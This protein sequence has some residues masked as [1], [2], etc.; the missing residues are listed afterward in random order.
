MLPFQAETL[1][2]P[3]PPKVRGVS[4][5]R[6]EAYFPSPADW[7]DEVLYF[8]LPD[9]FSDGNEAGRPR[10]DHSAVPA[11]RPPGWRWDEWARSGAERYQ[12]GTLAGVTSK[13]DYIRDLG[14]TTIWL[15]P[16]FKQRGH[17]DTFH[18]YAIQ[19]FLDVDP[20]FGTRR[21]L[22]DLVAAAHGKKL[23]VILD[24]I[25][26]HTGCNWLY[27]NGEREPRFRPFPEFYEKGQFFDASGNPTA[28]VASDD[29]GVW[30]E[31]L[32]ADDY[33]T[34]A[35]TGSL[36]AGDLF[37]DHAEFRRTDFLDLRD[38]NFDGTAALDD[39]AR[40]YKYWVA[41][42][43]CDGFRIDTLKHVGREAG[44]N[45]CGSIKEFASNL[46]KKD[47]F[48]V[49]EVAGSDHDARRFAEAIGS[50]LNATLDIGES[51]AAL[52]AVAQGL[53]PP[54]AYFDVASAWDPQ[55]GSHRN[56]GER[57]V[58]IL[59]D[60]DHVSGVKLRFSLDAPTDHQVAAGVAI[61][62]FALGIPCIYY[63]TEQALPGGPEASERAFLTGEP[64]DFGKSDR[65][66]REAMFGPEHPR[67]PG[68]AGRQ[69]GPAGLDP[70]LPGFGPAGTAGRHCFDPAHPAYRRIAALAAVRSRFP[71]LRYGR[72][73][74]RPI[75]N[76]GSPF[77]PA[78]AGEL[79][80][81]SR[82]LDDEEALC[83]VNGH[84]TAARGAD[85]LVDAAFNV[86][87][88]FEVVANSAQ[89]AAGAGYAGPHPVGQQLPVR[90]RDG[91]ALVEIRDLPPSEVLVLSNR[92]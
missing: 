72:Q 62:L 82:V 89:A 74:P 18:G 16:I 26:N 76:F 23:R 19:D 43:D 46:G 36:G 52:R 48:L 34:R 60:H 21:D 27:A 79:I 75:S 55:L 28:A 13:L 24:V 32:R 29:D 87:G 78:A 41:L 17:Q 6:R 35:G 38:L 53:A 42:T 77:A 57:H 66:L 58:S 12:G 88:L 31:E 84:G 4:L 44:R 10:L 92:P 22:V 68:L 9:R 51:R 81:W 49:G 11:A 5:P 69:P 50:N 59:D 83:V 3:R 90:V 40:C 63:G 8:L 7:R 61:Q 85:V 70:A 54:A 30:P 91:T 25:F 37:D 86:G 80:T 14:A 71:V 45:F 39:V 15:G 73:Y 33:Y 65:Y 67:R 20:R 56:A 1:A 47:F 64:F 2:K